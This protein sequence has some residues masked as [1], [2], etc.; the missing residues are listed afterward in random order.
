MRRFTYSPSQVASLERAISSER[1]GTYL[2]ACGGDLVSAIQMYEKNT[3]LSEA[4][5]GVLQAL[6]VTLRNSLHRELAAHYGVD[7]WFD[8]LPLLRAEAGALQRAKESLKRG[9][10]ANDSGSNRGRI[11]LRL[12]G[13]PDESSVFSEYLD[14]LPL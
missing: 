9:R 1:I 4:L 7:N 10:K 11:V 13:W 2:R 3:A 5:Y 12:L 14:T 8:C 6:E